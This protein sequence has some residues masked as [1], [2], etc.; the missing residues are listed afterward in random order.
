LIA[1]F[2]PSVAFPAAKPSSSTLSHPP[3]GV[4]GGIGGNWTK[5]NNKNHNSG[6][7]GGNNIKT[8]GG[9]GRGGSSGQTTAPTG[10]ACR[11]N[12]SWP[13]YIH[14]WQGHM[15]IYHGPVP[16]GQLC[17]QAFMATPGLYTSPNLLSR[18]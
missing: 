15:T 14:P 6:N 17:P 9:G 1:F 18:P 16:A 10:S 11:T 8:S 5:Y 7:G 13:T 2:G 3:N 12:A 4:S